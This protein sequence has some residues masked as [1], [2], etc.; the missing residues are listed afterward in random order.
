MGARYEHAA[1]WCGVETRQRQEMSMLPHP[2]TVCV[3]S[4]QQFQER[5]RDIAHERLAASAD[6]GTRSRPPGIGSA[7]SSHVSW[8]LALVIGIAAVALW[9]GSANAAEAPQRNPIPSLADVSATTQTARLF[10]VTGTGFSAGGRVYLAI[11]DQMGAKLYETR[12]ITASFPLLALAGPTGHEAASLP[13][14]G[15]GGTLRETF[16]NLCGATAMMR[17]YDEVATTWS[18][19]LT[20]EPA[21][22]DYVEPRSGPR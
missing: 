10:T 13:G 5:L 1:M 11:Y 21:C 17:A 20:V 7:R 3:I 8:R 4:A 16:A 19:W 15:H 18:S 2:E 9:I 6:A 12:W 22:V 14:S